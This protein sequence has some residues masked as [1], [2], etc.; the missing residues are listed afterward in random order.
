MESFEPNGS[1]AREEYGG[2]DP[3]L[4]DLVEL[5]SA[6][7]SA[8]AAFLCTV[9]EDADIPATTSGSNL[10]DLYGGHVAVST[11]ILVPRHLLDQARTTL[12]RARAQGQQAGIDSA[13]RSPVTDDEDVMDGKDAIE[14]EEALALADVPMDERLARLRPLV[15]VWVFRRDRPQHIAR[16]LAASGLTREDADRFMTAFCSDRTELAR[17]RRLPVVTGGL[18]LAFSL[19]LL[20]KGLLAGGVVMVFA[21]AFFAWAASLQLPRWQPQAAEPAQEDKPPA[22]GAPQP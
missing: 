14:M 18:L 10:G 6:R 2:E 9:L 13:F 19:L 22:S 15:R 4:T 11:K 17:V 1:E 8:E 16:R 7:H 5:T 20:A 3:R 21:L 12:D